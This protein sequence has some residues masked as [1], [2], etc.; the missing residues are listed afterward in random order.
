MQKTLIDP[1]YEAILLRVDELTPE[2]LNKLPYGVIQLDPT[3]KVLQYNE[4]EATLARLDPA[5]VVGKNFFAQVAPC[6]RV[7]EFH[8][9]FLEGVARKRLSETFAF[10]FKFA[11]GWRA[12]D[13]SMMY[14]EKSHTVWLVVSLSERPAES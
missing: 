14:S 12:V 11:H 7:R 13:I 3:G 5:D 4:I 2:E 1:R 10:V 6:T 8:G 9:L